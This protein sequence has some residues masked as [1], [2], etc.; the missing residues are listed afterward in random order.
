MSGRWIAAV[1]T[2]LVVV[3]AVHPAIAAA[4]PMSPGPAVLAALD[5]L[6]EASHPQRLP[7]DVEIAADRFTHPGSCTDLGAAYGAAD[8]PLPTGASVT[9][10]GAR[11]PIQ[12]SAPFG[13]SAILTEDQ[14]AKGRCVYSIAIEPTVTVDAPDVT[15]DSGFVNVGCLTFLGVDLLVAQF[16]NQGVV[17]SLLASQQNKPDWVLSIVPGALADVMKLSGDAQVPGMV[18]I[19]GSGTYDGSTLAFSGAGPSGAVTATMTCTPFTSL[20]S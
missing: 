13:P 14:P 19:T 17:T 4:P 3:T 15:L 18:Q 12:V 6:N 1:A 2:S 8:A 11:D 20:S 5:R 9:V 16:Q 7:G 10:G